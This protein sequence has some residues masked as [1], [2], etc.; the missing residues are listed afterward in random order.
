MSNPIFSFKS[1]LSELEHASDTLADA[2]NLRRRDSFVRDSS[3]RPLELGG[4]STSAIAHA[5]TSAYLA[6]DYSPQ[7]AALLGGIRE[8][9]SYSQILLRQ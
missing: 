9:K 6:H 5:L 3:D 8:L 4:A 2:N 7:E 1:Y